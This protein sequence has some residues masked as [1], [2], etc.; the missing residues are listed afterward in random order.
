M[1]KFQPVLYCLLAITLFCFTSCDKE[2]EI[3]PTPRILEVE[4]EGGTFPVEVNMAGPDWQVVKVV[5]KNGDVRIAGKVY[6]TEGNL[7]S[8]NY[9]VSLEGEGRV[10]SVWGDKGFI[11]T[12]SGSDSLVIEVLENGTGEPFSFGIVLQEGHFTHE[13]IVQQKVSEG[14]RFGSI[15]YLMNEEDGDSLYT[16]RTMTY[17]HTLSTP[18][19]ISFSPYSGPDIMNTSYFESDDP[20]AFTWIAK[21]SIPVNVPQSIVDD[22]IY[23]SGSKNV[24]GAITKTT[25]MNENPF[26]ASLEIPAGE[27][28]TFHVELEWRHRAVSYVLSLV[29]NRTGAEKK[30]EGKWI[31]YTPTG[32]YETVKEW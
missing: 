10:E 11:I 13:I 25:Y 26:M 23:L 18:Q 5:N 12:R 30:I 9:P 19:I 27:K 32:N 6:S 31:Q 2:E 15:E 16:R 24:Y 29:N 21:D 8:E 20:Y 7:V 28:V 1:T 4:G 17:S 14:Y 3:T 22:K